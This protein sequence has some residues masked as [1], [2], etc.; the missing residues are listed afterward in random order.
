MHDIDKI[1]QYF[2]ELSSKI[3]LSN[4]LNLM[5]INILCE[6]Q[7]MR[8][9]NMLF[10]WKLYNA[11]SKSQNT[12]ALDLIDDENRLA[13]Q[14]TSNTRS[15]KI[16]ET[17]A[18]AK[19]TPF[20][21]YQLY[22]FYLCDAISPQ[23]KKA[24]ERYNIRA[25]CFSDLIQGF[26]GNSYKTKEFIRQCVELTVQEQ[27][28]EYLYYP[29]K[30][31]YDDNFGGY[32]YDNNPSYKIKI[33]SDWEEYQ[34]YWLCEIKAISKHYPRKML[35][36][37]IALFYNDI[38]VHEDVLVEFY[39]ERLTIALPHHLFCNHKYDLFFDGYL[40]DSEGMEDFPSLL[41]Y[42]FNHKNNKITYD[43]FVNQRCILTYQRDFAKFVP[44]I[45]FKNRDEFKGFEKFVNER[46][47][48]F[49][50]ENLKNKYYG[51]DRVIMNEREHR[52]CCLHFWVYDLY[53]DEFCFLGE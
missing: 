35:K 43:D 3:K 41:T 15:S 10:D 31:S 32:Y 24:V 4:H 37:D 53:Y 25:L 18:K 11:N 40:L 46:I 20:A 16:K 22:M 49:D 1:I 6:N 34:D 5:D 30:W 39:E 28:R 27:F 26:Y 9:L 38:K 44:L 45:F 14:V 7:V 8:A 52:F 12:E 36:Q 29:N 48:N 33:E 21:D 2:S 13:I 23:T 17:I 51:L 42:F 47:G 19:K 50:Y